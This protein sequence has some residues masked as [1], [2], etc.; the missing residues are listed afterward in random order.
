ML[1]RWDV[2]KT[3]MRAFDE[4]L[5]LRALHVQFLDKIAQALRSSGVLLDSVGTGGE[6]FTHDRNVFFAHVLAVVYGNAV[7]NEPVLVLCLKVA[8]VPDACIFDFDDLG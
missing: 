4:P 7:R 6:C 8:Y 2:E 5:G 3:A 1:T